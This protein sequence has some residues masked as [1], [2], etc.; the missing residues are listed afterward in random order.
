MQRIVTCVVV[1]LLLATVS[2]A[3]QT[4]LKS[5]KVRHRRTLQTP[6]K[7]FTQI[8]SYE[9]L[10]S[11]NSVFITAFTFIIIIIIIKPLLDLAAKKAGL[12]QTIEKKTICP[13]I[14]YWI[15]HSQEMN[16]KQHSKFSQSIIS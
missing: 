7:Y 8:V 13:H 11:R 4:V 3:I 14:N 6:V 9:K 15:H 12:Q 1:K 16:T 2:A 10:S 5:L